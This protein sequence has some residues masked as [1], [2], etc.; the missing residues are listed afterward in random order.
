M[1]QNIFDRS[2]GFPL[3]RQLAEYIK[4]QIAA[5]EYRPGDLLPSESDYIR[6]YNLSRTTVRLAFGLITNAG[7]IRREQG[8]GTVVVSQVRSKLPWLSSFTE[9][10]YRNSR[11]PSVTFLGSQEVESSKEISQALELPEATKILKVIRLRK[12]DDEPIGLAISWMN[13]VQFPV[14]KDLDYSYLS[15]YEAFEKVLRL[16]IRNAQEN[17]FAD[18]I[19]EDETAF[20]NLKH[21]S[22]VL[23]MKRTTYI[24]GEQ[25]QQG[26]PIE[27]V[28]CVFNGSAYFVEVELFRQDKY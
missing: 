9:E 24:Q 16:K 22:P 21:G 14:L 27:Y 1:K 18:L 11:T 3:Y 2:S 15:M 28:N 19:A 17:I 4:K 8:R 7:L 25:E 26:I 23:R 12:V 20:L 13:I 6:D 10:A 5:G